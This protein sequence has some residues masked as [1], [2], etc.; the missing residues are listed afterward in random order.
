MIKAK[1]H[2]KDWLSARLNTLGKTKKDLAV[3]MGIHPQHVNRLLLKIKLTPAQFNRMANFLGC[4]L[5]MLIRFWDNQIGDTTLFSQQRTAKF[6][7][8]LAKRQAAAAEGGDMADAALPALSDVCDP[9]DVVYILTQIEDWLKEHHKEA[10]VQNKIYVTFSIYDTTRLLA[11]AEKKA[12][13]VKLIESHLGDKV[14]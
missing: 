4:E 8:R 1:K 10:T 6:K 7:A 12:Q 9:D 5:D 11:P 2:N 13:I 3:A 14:S